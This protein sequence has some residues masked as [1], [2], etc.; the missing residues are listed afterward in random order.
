MLLGRAKTRAASPL[1]LR[2]AL[3]AGVPVA[4]GSQL[5]TIRVCTGHRGDTKIPNSRA[6]HCIKARG[7]GLPP[8]TA[9]IKPWREMFERPSPALQKKKKNLENWADEILPEANVLLENTVEM[10]SLYHAEWLQGQE[11]RERLF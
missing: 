3:S 5:E 9:E 4:T 2:Q 1:H 7:S 6:A 8:E 10:L 11:G